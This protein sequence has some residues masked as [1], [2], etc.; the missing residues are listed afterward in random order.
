MAPPNGKCTHEAQARRA[1]VREVDL[2]WIDALRWIANRDGFE[3]VYERAG[4]C[5]FAIFGAPAAYE[6]HPEH[7][8]A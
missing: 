2:G 5:I 3:A 8:P 6:D 4:D 7:A 1:P